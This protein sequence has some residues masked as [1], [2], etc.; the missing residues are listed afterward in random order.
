[1]GG[2]DGGDAD[3]DGYHVMVM[4]V[5]MVLMVVMLTMMMMAMMWAMLMRMH[6]VPLARNVDA[7]SGC[8]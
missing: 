3:D 2:S 6:V 8:F 1:L 4:T 5:V 7:S